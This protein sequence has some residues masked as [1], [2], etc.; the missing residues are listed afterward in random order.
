MALYWQKSFSPS[1]EWLLFHQTRV[2]GNDSSMPQELTAQWKMIRGLRT[3][4]NGSQSVIV[5]APTCHSA[6]RFVSSLTLKLNCQKVFQVVLFLVTNFTKRSFQL[7][8]H[9][10]SFRFRLKNAFSV[11][12][13]IIYRPFATEW[14]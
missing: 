3:V 12:E 2:S 9:S 14:S 7:S 4:R 8:S 13:D 5:P 10:F 6:F 11:C 1:K